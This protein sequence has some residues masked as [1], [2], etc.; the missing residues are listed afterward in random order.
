MS[1]RILYRQDAKV[2]PRSLRR[3][4]AHSAFLSL[5]PL[6]LITTLKNS[7]P[8]S[9]CV[10]PLPHCTA[11]NFFPVS[12]VKQINTTL[13]HER[14]KMPGQRGNPQSAQTRTQISMRPL[15]CH[16]QKGKPPVQTQKPE[17]GASPLMGCKRSAAPQIEGQKVSSS[18][19]CDALR[20][21][22]LPNSSRK[23]FL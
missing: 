12:M 3:N 23:V 2:S 15:R 8:L 9:L 16:G 10:Y 17:G 4:I 18:Q 19:I 5:R 1:F 21:V 13:D 11:M 7:A 20:K 22:G 14:Q 6:R